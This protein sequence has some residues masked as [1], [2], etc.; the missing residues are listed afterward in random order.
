[1]EFWVWLIIAC[2]FFILATVYFVRAL[3]RKEKSVWK[4]LKDWF[5]NIIDIFS[6]CG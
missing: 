6:G 5:I 1:M 4:S 2:A 3:K